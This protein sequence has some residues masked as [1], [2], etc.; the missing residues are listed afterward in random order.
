MNPTDYDHLA[1][2]LNHASVDGTRDDP[3]YTAVKEL[4]DGHHAATPKPTTHLMFLDVE[5]TGLDPSLHE[6]W[7]I[8]YA[9]ED[10]PVQSSTVE[11]SSHRLSPQAA[12]VNHYF[13]RTTLVHKLTHE[14][15]AYRADFEREF[16]RQLVGATIVAANPAYDTA[17]LRARYGADLWHYR[18]ID[19]ETFA[20]PV[21]GFARPPSF[22]TIVE[23]L[24]THYGAGI[25]L[26]D[27]SAAGD[28][29][30]LRSA[31]AKLVELAH[32]A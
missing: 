28:V 2:A 7:E 15:L 23:H 13:D 18:L 27:H 11:H 8:A 19:I 14:Q 9:L 10:G 26:P 31:Y 25:D 4:L 1:T 17:M 24:N 20:M 22:L 29:E 21:L 5:T 30:A 16:Q 12:A 3:L 6:V 32:P